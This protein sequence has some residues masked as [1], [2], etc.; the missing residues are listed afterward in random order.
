MSSVEDHVGS[1][2]ILR[3]LLSKVINN[4]ALP[5][6]PYTEAA[7]V[8]YKENTV[9]V[10]L[11][12]LDE[13]HHN[14]ATAL[15]SVRED[16]DNHVN[17]SYQKDKINE[18]VE[19]ILDKV[20]INL[21]RITTLRSEFD[22][23]SYYPQIDLD[24]KFF[25]IS[26]DVEQNIFQMNTLTQELSSYIAA[27]YYDS[28]EWEAHKNLL[29]KQTEE[30]HDLFRTNM[31]DDIRQI[32]ADYHDMLNEKMEQYYTKSEADQLHSSAA[33]EVHYLTDEFNYFKGDYIAMNAQSASDV[34]ENTNAAKKQIM[35]N[36]ELQIS[37]LRESI[38]SSLS[39]QSDEMRGLLTQANDLISQLSS[40]IISRLPSEGSYTSADE[41][42]Y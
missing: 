22:A 5:L 21:D 16:F 1:D 12:T 38:D 13:W 8:Y 37:E 19:E 30:L 31:G 10:M 18:M 26:E 2:G 7:S 25:L 42:E 20:N 6:Y 24:Q 39:S 29:L 3:S 33:E 4:R 36:T 17:D 9:Q 15:R 40:T 34:N 32:E 11:D 14:L 35:D 23:L 41:E 27:N 28:N